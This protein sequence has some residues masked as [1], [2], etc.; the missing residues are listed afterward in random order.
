MRRMNLIGVVLLLAL[1]T[2]GVVAQEATPPQPAAQAPVLG[3]AAKLRIV[4]AVQGADSIGAG[5]D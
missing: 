1:T 5:N 3:E 4:V 2:G